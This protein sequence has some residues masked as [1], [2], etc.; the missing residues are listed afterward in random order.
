MLT[1]LLKKKKKL[2]LGIDVSSSSVKVLELSQHNGRYRVEAYANERLPTEALTSESSAQNDEIIGQV[3]RKALL[4]SRS[5]L[6]DAAITVPSSAVIIKTLPMNAKLSDDEMDFQIQTEAGQHIHT[7]DGE[8]ALDWEVIGPT[9]SVPD[10]VDVL[11]VACHLETVERC[12]DTVELAE[13]NVS[14]VDVEAFCIERVF[15]LLQEQ[16]AG[17]AQDT[18]AIIDM[19]RNKTLINVIHEGRSIFTREQNF[20]GQMLTE[21][22]MLRYGYT[23][24]QADELK[25]NGNYPDDFETEVL[26]PFQ[27]AAVQTVNRLLQLFYTACQFNEVDHII[28]AGGVATTLNLPEMVQNGTQVKTTVANPFVSMSLSNKVNPNTLSNDAS[29][30]LVACGLAMRSFT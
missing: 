28:L 10:S 20:G 21:D 2:L 16:L 1:K 5:H 3:V 22:I 29:S 15:S 13:A 6:K 24:E 7:T 26:L 17:E 19:G 14:I 11:V 9:D 12:K 30:L 18:V 4:R 25:E 23:L 27:Q 8:I